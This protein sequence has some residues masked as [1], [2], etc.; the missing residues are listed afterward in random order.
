MNKKGQISI[1]IMY[2]VGVLLVIFLILTAATFQRKID[3][4]NTRE[5]IEKRNDC[6]MISNAMNRVSSLGEGYS[7]T[8]R[9]I[10]NFDVFDTGLI[11]IGDI[12]GST[13]EEIEVICSFN[14]LLNQHNYTGYG[15]WKVT[16]SGGNLSL[17]V[18][19]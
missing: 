4:E 12:A 8:F 17:N 7:S 2:S 15:S 9:T 13:P 18:N 14:G 19:T 5:T 1:E 6:V 10:Y 11:V 3:V 16:K